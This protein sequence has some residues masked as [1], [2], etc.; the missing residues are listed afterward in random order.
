MIKKKD[1]NIL[2]FIRKIFGADPRIEKQ[3]KDTG[4]NK[5]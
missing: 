4:I 1:C 2:H 3:A 5:V